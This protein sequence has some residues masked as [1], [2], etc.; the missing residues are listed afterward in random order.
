[1]EREI[2]NTDGDDLVKKQQ[3]AMVIGDG[4]FLS[5][6]YLGNSG[7]LEL[8][9]RLINWL[10]RDDAFITIPAKIATDTQLEMSGTTLGIIGLGFLFVLPLLLL[11][12]GIMIGWRRRTS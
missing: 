11:G 3:R 5:N 7:N 1:M 12:T 2:E 8:G 9:I 6:T 10:S 4:D